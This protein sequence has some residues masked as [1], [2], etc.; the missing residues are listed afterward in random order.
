MMLQQIKCN[1]YVDI[2]NNKNIIFNNVAQIRGQILGMFNCLSMSNK[3]TSI[4][5]SNILQFRTLI[6]T[7]VRYLLRGV[8]IFL[9]LASLYFVCCYTLINFSYFNNI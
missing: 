1:K 2:C 8:S 6:P 5:S 9:L 7:G 4:C 3:T